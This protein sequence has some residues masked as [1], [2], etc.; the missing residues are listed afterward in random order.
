M[1]S[2]SHRIVT[3]PVPAPFLTPRPLSKLS[4]A[5]FN[6][7][8]QRLICK[9]TVE[10]V[11]LIVIIKIMLGVCSIMGNYLQLNWENNIVDSI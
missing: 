6:Y 7:T 3:V 2:Q 1:T 10:A 11:I 9:E 5:D 4:Q 8:S